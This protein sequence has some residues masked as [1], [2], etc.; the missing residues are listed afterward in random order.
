VLAHRWWRW[1]RAQNLA[2]FR[3]WT[4][5]RSWYSRMTCSLV[6]LSWNYGAS[7]L[8][9]CLPPDMPACDSL[10][11]CRAPAFALRPR[12]AHDADLEAMDKALTF[13]HGSFV[14][15]AKLLDMSPK[16]FRNIVRGHA[17]LKAKW[18]KRRGNPGREYRLPFRIEPHH[19]DCVT[20]EVVKECIT[21]LSAAQ[22]ADVRTWLE[23]EPTAQTCHQAPPI[24]SSFLGRSRGC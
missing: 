14:A 17:C 2:G 6:R 12:Y 21:C 1:N 22:Q 11:M 23:K 16:R 10:Y 24:D 13:T 19:E 18:G 3:W 15:A 5:D 20:P 9:S 7:I 4:R 8:R